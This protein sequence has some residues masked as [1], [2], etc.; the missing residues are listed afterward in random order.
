MLK[1]YIT[2]PSHVIE[3][4]PIQVHEDLTYEEKPVQILAREEK[5]LRNKT[6]P[7]VKV[8]WRNYKVL[9]NKT[10]PLIKRKIPIT[11]LIFEDENF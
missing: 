8:L 7:L 3:H 10:I 5:V 4:E 2:N 1:K 11:I 9:R 6:I